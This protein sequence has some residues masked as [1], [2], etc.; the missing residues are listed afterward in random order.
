VT[1]SRALRVV[2]LAALFWSSA[3]LVEPSGEDG[4]IQAPEAIA[5]R[6]E[7]RLRALHDEADRLAAQQRSVLVQLRQLEVA[8]QIAIAE[9]RRAD[10]AVAEA[11]AEA[12]ALERQVER[13]EGERDAV[14]PAIESRLVEIYKLGRG[15]YARLL[16][17]ATDLRRLGQATRTVAALAARDQQ[18]FHAYERRLGDLN[19]A[20]EVLIAR[21]EALISHRVKAAQARAAADRA[22]IAQN[23][24]VR[25]IDERRDLNAQLTSELQEAQQ[26]LEATLRD[27]TAGSAHVTLPIGPFRG[28]LP[29]PA[30]GDLQRRSD[31]AG[32]NTVTQRQGVEIAAPEG[33]SVQAVYD[34]RVAFAGGFDGLGNLVIVDHGAQTFTLYG[35][36]MEFDVAQGTF[37]AQGQILGRTGASTVGR[38][39][40]YFELRVGG[41]PVDPLQWLSRAR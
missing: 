37:V 16:L 38:S 20:L 32:S 27:T 2:S 17:S 29:W 12:D 25:E 26:R 23:A 15:Q 5:R 7:E 1:P 39:S 40:L 36:L 35:H 3:R 34:G 9:V 10:A 6:A 41:R 4:A 22:L 19:E 14:Q 11:E 13:L 33:T 18:R 30:P 28:A 31:G 8:R 24:R 21:D